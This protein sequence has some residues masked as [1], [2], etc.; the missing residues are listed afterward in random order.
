MYGSIDL[1]IRRIQAVPLWRWSMQRCCARAGV[2]ARRVI[3][4]FGDGQEKAQ[5][6]GMAD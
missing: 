2:I 3:T 6:S 4:I 1:Q 5:R